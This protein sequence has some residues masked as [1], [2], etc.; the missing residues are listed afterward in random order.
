MITRCPQEITIT[1]ARNS[2]TILPCH[3]GTI[4][5]LVFKNVKGAP[6]EQLWHRSA[7]PIQAGAW[8]DGGIPILFPFAGRVWCDGEVGKYRHGNQIYGMPIH[9]FL[10]GLTGQ[11]LEQETSQ[12][13]AEFTDNEATRASYP[14]KFR[15]T[16]Y[17]EINEASL[18]IRIH[19][20]NLGFLGNGGSEE[21]PVAL[22]FHPYFALTEPLGEVSPELLLELTGR[23]SFRVNSAGG[24]GEV[25]SVGPID[26]LEINRKDNQ[27]SIIELEP[28][29]PIYLA[30]KEQGT[31]TVLRTEGSLNYL[32]LWGESTSKFFCVEP[33]MA[34]PDAPNHK[35]G[36]ALL[37]KDKD[38]WIQFS[39]SNEPQY[40]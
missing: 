11:I 35:Y 9:G 23:R 7:G 36:T 16:A 17:Y 22:G 8:P 21:M 15:L 40:S 19:I 18:S 14:W 37:G 26:R 20:V 34:P 33:W 29:G 2:A 32:V 30:G 3:G 38:I 12:V 39:I 4:S 27:N 24:Q 1:S 10:Y 31:R 28:A 5:S 25:S 6:K 13:S